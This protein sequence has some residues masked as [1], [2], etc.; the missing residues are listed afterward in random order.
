MAFLHRL[1]EREGDAGAHP[2]RSRSARCRASRDEVGGAEA[3]AANVAGQPV[4]ILRDHLHGIGAV[5]LVDAHRPRG[6]D[7]VGVQ[8][9]H[10]LA[11]DLLLGP[12]GNDARGA[13]GADPGHLAQPAGLLL[14]HLEHRLTECTHQLLG[15]DRADAADHA[16]AEVLLDALQRGRRR[17]L[18]ERGLELEAVGA[19][20]DP[21]AAHLDPLAGRDHGGVADDGD[22]IALTAGLDPQHA[23][24]AFGVVECH[25]LDQPGQRLRLLAGVG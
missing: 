11:D 7:A 20:V 21:A 24:A 9:Q 15:V 17:R 5:G 14:D 23:E 2:D 10:D 19:I 16:G 13:L 4:G 1:G 6:A 22:Q 12:A 25:P 8:E 18:E 3:D